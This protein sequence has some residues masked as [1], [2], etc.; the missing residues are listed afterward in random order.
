M[1]MSKEQFQGHLDR[2]IK[3]IERYQKRAKEGND[4]K[5]RAVDSDMHRAGIRVP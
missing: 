3:V 2:M 4:D 1:V 5:R